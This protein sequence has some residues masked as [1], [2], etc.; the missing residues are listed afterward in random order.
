MLAHGEVEPAG[1]GL[2]LLRHVQP[3][4]ASPR[5]CCS[6]PDALYLGEHERGDVH[7]GLECDCIVRI[8]VVEDNATRALAWTERHCVRSGGEAPPVRGFW[9]LLMRF[10]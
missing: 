6:G 10:D 1:Q 5:E 9:Q 4:L 7:T 2:L 8:V 3:E